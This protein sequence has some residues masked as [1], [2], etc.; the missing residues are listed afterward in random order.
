[1]KNKKAIIVLLTMVFI[2]GLIVSLFLLFKNIRV[3]KLVNEC[4]NYKE[5]QHF[6]KPISVA[7]T[8]KF[9]GCLVSCWGAAFTKIS[10]DLQYPRFSGYVRNSGNK[11]A[12][13]FMKEGR[14]LII[15]GKWIDV[16]GSYASVFGNK[17]VPT[18]EIDR[19]EIV[20]E[21]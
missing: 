11:I 12:D 21:K 6:K 15:Y 1:M 10:S 8:A 18:I 7:W 9:D 20:N 2:S 4:D 3:Q 16:S 13:E 19:I 14:V 17:C 5:I